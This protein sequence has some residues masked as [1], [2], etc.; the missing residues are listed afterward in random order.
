MVKRLPPEQGDLFKMHIVNAAVKDDIHSMEYPLF[1]LA[2]RADTE[3][4][5]YRDA[6]SGKSLK[7]IPSAYG[8]P[9]IFD[10]DLLIY[11]MSQLAA[12]MNQ[13][14]PVSRTIVFQTSDFLNATKP[15][16][17]GGKN[18]TLIIGSLRRLRGTTLETN[19]ETGGK[20]ETEGFGY[21]DD[22]KIVQPTSRGKGALAVQMSL[23]PWLYRALMNFEI[24]TLPKGYFALGQPIERRLYEL[25]RKHAGSTGVIWKISMQRLLEKTGSKQSPNEFA[26]QVRAIIKS[27]SLPDYR[28]FLDKAKKPYNVVFITRN[29]KAL[30][31]ELEKK[32]LF[33]WYEELSKSNPRD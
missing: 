9:T 6:R 27:D 22:Y 5:E 20:L 7:I 16:K 29:N 19:I 11:A 17:D 25:A 28:V 3:V 18:Y 21:I 31:E 23:S 24:L 26:K 30:T 1:S 15:D 2:K 32:N 10:K 4:R 8:M 12:A 33:D 14:Q 13:G